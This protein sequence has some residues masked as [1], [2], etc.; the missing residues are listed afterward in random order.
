MR[1][2]LKLVFALVIMVL[3]KQGGN[4][5]LQFVLK[6]LLCEGRSDGPLQ[7]VVRIY[8]ALYSEITLSIIAQ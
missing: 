4:R 3:Q 5:D 7:T 1:E 2:V 8:T 6:L